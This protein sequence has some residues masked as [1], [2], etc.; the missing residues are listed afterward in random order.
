MLSATSFQI[1]L[2]TGRNWQDD[3]GLYVLGGVF[4]AATAVWYPM[5][6]IKPSVY[7]LSFPWI[8]F[9][10]AFLLIGIPSVHSSVAPA[11]RALSNAAT[12]CYAVASAAGF[13]FFGLNFGEEA[14]CLF[15][16]TSD[17]S[18]SHTRS[19]VLLQKFG[20]FEHVLCKGRSKSGS[21]HCG[22]GVINSTGERMATFHHGGFS[23]QCGR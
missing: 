10:L 14:V 16:F 18:S 8:F 1:T 9:G 5:F 7:V 3:V 23:W 4:L 21:L 20:R 17:S 19:R 2:L 11:H 13:L 12:W 15:S 6:R 22:I